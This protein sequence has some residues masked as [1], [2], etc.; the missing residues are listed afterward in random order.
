[1]G[2]LICHRAVAGVSDAGPD[3]KAS[4]R[5]GAGNQLGVEGRQI[6]LCPAPSHKDDE[7][8]FE[9]V[10]AREG[11]CDLRGRLGA[12]DGRRLET[13][14]KAVAGPLQLPGEVSVGLRAWA[15]HE[16]DPQGDEGERQPPVRLE[17][18]LGREGAQQP[19]AGGR[20]PA[21]ERL[22]VEGG[23]GEAEL[24]AALPDRDLASQAHDEP[25]RE[26]DSDRGELVLDDGP[27]AGPARDLERG[28]GVA[29]HRAAA[30]G[31]KAVSGLHSKAVL[32]GPRA[33]DSGAPSKSSP[34]RSHR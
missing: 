16:P 29:P 9:G 20:D 34:C 5:D 15:R 3:G 14:V 24:A 21:D 17:E 8:R 11:S 19:S 28:G 30:T 26:L 33:R 31:L 25:G 23:H 12:L 7:L 18:T 27:V 32:H 13:D 22:D 4:P 2:D 1:M 6:A 10:E